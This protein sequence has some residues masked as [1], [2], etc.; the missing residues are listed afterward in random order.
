MGGGG[1]GGGR[2]SVNQPIYR[3]IS[4]IVSRSP[5]LDFAVLN[6]TL[7]LKFVYCS[8]NKAY[9]ENRKYIDTHYASKKLKIAKKSSTKQ[10]QNDKQKWNKTYVN[11]TVPLSVEKKRATK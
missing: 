3:L 9:G 11:I 10:T 8:I 2:V 5:W 6:H 4:G 7:Q 1:G